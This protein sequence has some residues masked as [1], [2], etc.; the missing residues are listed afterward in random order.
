MTPG[1][2]AVKI[3]LPLPRSQGSLRILVPEKNSAANARK[4]YAKIAPPGGKTQ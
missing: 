1:F 4:I 2:D 3:E